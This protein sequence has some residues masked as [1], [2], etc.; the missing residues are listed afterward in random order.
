MAILASLQEGFEIEF[1]LLVGILCLVHA[2]VTVCAYS[3]L[4]R[5]SDIGKKV[6][7][8]GISLLF[9]CVNHQTQ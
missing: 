3:I 4:L 5:K 2:G 1:S 6:P 7:F 9:C 8:K